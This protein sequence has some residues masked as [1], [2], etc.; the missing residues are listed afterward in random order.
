MIDFII[1]CD[2]L[3][4]NAHLKKVNR[5]E[6]SINGVNKAILDIQMSI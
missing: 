5:I 1:A 4:N 6:M 2:S 3:N